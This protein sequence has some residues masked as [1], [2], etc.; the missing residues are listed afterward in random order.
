MSEVET[1]TKISKN[2]TLFLTSADLDFDRHACIENTNLVKDFTGKNEDFMLLS[3]TRALAND[4]KMDERNLT[5]GLNAAYVETN[6]ELL[7]ELNDL[8]TKIKNICQKSST[9]FEYLLS[10][11]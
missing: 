7:N 9:T 10:L 5:T 2:C 3:E 8:H 1:S 6:Q 11:K 4:W